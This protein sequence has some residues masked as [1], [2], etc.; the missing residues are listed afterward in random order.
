MPTKKKAGAEEGIL[1]ST[2]GGSNIQINDETSDITVFAVR[3]FFTYSPQASHVTHNTDVTCNF[4]ADSAGVI[5]AVTPLSRTVYTPTDMTSVMLPQEILEQGGN[6]NL[7]CNNRIMLRTASAASA[8]IPTAGIMEFIAGTSMGLRTPELDVWLDSTATVSVG[9]TLTLCG[10]RA[11]SYQLSSPS[12]TPIPSVTTYATTVVQ[13]IIAG[14]DG[15]TPA[16]TVNMGQGGSHSLL[17]QTNGV[18]STIFS[19]QGT[20]NL[21]GAGL[22]T[23]ISGL[24][25]TVTSTN[26]VLL[27]CGASSV[28]MTASSLTLT[29]GA[30]QIIIT[31]ASIVITSPQLIVPGTAIITEIT[32]PYMPLE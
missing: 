31:P 10:P 29:C 11:Y 25:T 5:N 13:N 9:S 16:Y 22:T 15:G 28:E 3:S 27:T 23:S 18:C 4:T 30:S 17:F 14:S 7:Q 32:S 26:S 20:W 1:L 19:G 2:K 21:S 8:A 6:W 12:F 24:D